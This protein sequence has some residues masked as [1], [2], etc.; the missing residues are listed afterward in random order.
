VFILRSEKYHSTLLA[1]MTSVR[2]VTKRPLWKYIIRFHD[3][4]IFILSISYFEIKIE[5]LEIRLDNRS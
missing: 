4:I 2:K 5:K 1:K 3:Y